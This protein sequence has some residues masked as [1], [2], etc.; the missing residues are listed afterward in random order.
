ML[1]ARDIARMQ[2]KKRNL[3]KEL[4]KTILEG[5]SKKIRVAADMGQIQAFLTVPTFVVGFPVFDPIPATVYL[6][7]QLERLGYTV[8]R[9]D[10]TQIYVSWGTTTRD[11]VVVQEELPPLPVF[12]NLRKVADNIRKN[13]S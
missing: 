13:Q 11:P 12:A 8:T 7:R 10:T 9:Y 2:T 5:F 4:Y 6:M 1:S 3:K